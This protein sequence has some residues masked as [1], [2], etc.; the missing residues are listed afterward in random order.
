MFK[1]LITIITFG[2][3]GHT[4]QVPV[5]KYPESFRTY[6]ACMAVVG[7]DNYAAEITRIGRELAGATGH[8][9]LIE[10]KCVLI[11]DANGNPAAPP[12]PEGPKQPPGLLPSFPAYPSD[13]RG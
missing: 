1:I 7:S 4:I 10:S 8:N 5:E 3:G 13:Y 12:P 11:T 9:N 2:V 6:V